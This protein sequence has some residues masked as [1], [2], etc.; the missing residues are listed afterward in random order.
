MVL[1]FL[2]FLFSTFILFKVVVAV[3]TQT[4]D[5]VNSHRLEPEVSFFVYSN[6]FLS[7]EQP[8]LDQVSVWKSEENE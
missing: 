5:S 2:F 4:P 8:W 3:L 7:A 1:F 6:Q